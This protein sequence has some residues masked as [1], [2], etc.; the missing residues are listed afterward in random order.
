MTMT[1]R[2][3]ALLLAGT[4]T[5]ASLTGCQNPAQTP[6]SSSSPAVSASPEVTLDPE[7]VK[8]ICQF[9]VG[10]DADEV[11]ATV[12][13][14]EITAEEL[15]CW[16]VMYTDDILEYYGLTEIPWET[17][18]EG[19]TLAY[20]IVQDALNGAATYH[21]VERKAEEEKLAVSQEEMDAIYASL[22]SI[23][24]DQQE[25]GLTTRAYLQQ[26]V[27][28]SELYVWYCKCTYLLQQLAD[29]RFGV[30]SSRYPSDD[31]VLRFLE[32]DCGVYEVKHILLAT[33]DLETYAKLDE[34]EIAKKKAQAENLLQQLRDS[35]DPLAKFDELMKQYSED[36]GLAT[37]PNGYVF[38]TETTVDPAFEAAALALEEGHISNVVE[39]SSGF[40]IILRMPL[41]S[42]D[43]AEFRDVYIEQKMVE[44]EKLWLE[45]CDIQTNAQFEKVDP[46]VFYE[47]LE[48]YRS[49]VEEKTAGQN[50]EP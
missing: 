25:L 6:A 31:E 22:K 7:T 5:L 11:V 19:K 9:T 49:A 20:Y 43:P 14:M 44:E 50:S 40:H 8:D 38:Q 37:N 17:E 23:T 41:T 36:P 42:I 32:E 12:D 13:G 18:N 29:N 3:A 47:K 34:T 10:L 27:L 21:L 1:R 24:E 16:V 33:L 48:E 35:E 28:T 46:K 15:L 2:L 4:M 39:G 45:E 26:F 30:T